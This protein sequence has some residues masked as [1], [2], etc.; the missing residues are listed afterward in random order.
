MRAPA[1]ATFNVCFA[2]LAA[3]VC[4]SRKSER[5]GEQGQIERGPDGETAQ[6]AKER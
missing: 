1:V 4:G 5:S 2:E 6:T 3:G